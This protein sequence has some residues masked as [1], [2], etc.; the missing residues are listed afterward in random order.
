MAQAMKAQDNRVDNALM[1]PNVGTTAARI[2]NFIRLN[3]PEFHGSMVDE[4]PEEFI[5]EL[6]KI[7]VTVFE[8]I[9]LR[10]GN[11]SVK[12][13]AL[14]LTDELTKYAPIMVADSRSRMR[15]TLYF[16]TSYVAMIFDIGPEILSNPFHVST[17]GYKFLNPCLESITIVNEFLDVFPNDLHGVPPK[18]EIEFGIEKDH[19][20]H[21]RIVFQIL[22]GRELCVFQSQDFEICFHEKDLNLCQI[23][24]LELL[25]DYD[26][27]VIYHPSHTNVVADVLS[28]LSI[29]SVAH[30]EDDKKKLVHDVHRLVGLC[31]RLVDSNDCGVV[32]HNG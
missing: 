2:R 22:K 25:K 16:V 30:V 23:R 8:F 18:R 13:Y 29:G 27:S 31:V 1:I 9:N 15:A 21:L 32:V 11:I 20:E 4:D 5:D 26:M 14:K 17:R 19:V 10:Q 12:K 7:E 24:L 3:P 6:F 28:Q